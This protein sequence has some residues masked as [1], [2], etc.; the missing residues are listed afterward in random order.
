MLS[1]IYKILE[2]KSGMIFNEKE[3]LFYTDKAIYN[4]GLTCYE[5]NSVQDFSVQIKPWDNN[6]VKSYIFDAWVNSSD[7]NS[8]YKVQVKANDKNGF[9]SFS[10]NCI[11]FEQNYRRKGICKHIV[12]V[13]LKY[14]R[15]KEGHVKKE[16][17]NFQLDQ[18]ISQLKNNRQLVH[19]QEIKFF[20]KLEFHSKGNVR[21]S[22]EVKVGV[23]KLCK[24]KDIGR[25]IYAYET[26]EQ[27][28]LGKDFIYSKLKYNFSKLDT[29]FINIIREINENENLLR[30]NYVFLRDGYKLVNGNKV[31]PCDISIRRIF[32]LFKEERI[33]CVIDGKNYG[34]IPIN[35][36]LVPLDLKLLQK[37]SDYA[38]CYDGHLP[39][40]LTKKGDVMFYKGEIYL[41]NEMRFNRFKPFYEV[42][43]TG[44]N[45]IINNSKKDDLKEII[46]PEIS[47]LSGELIIDNN[48]RKQLEIDRLKA[49]FYLDKDKEEILL[50]VKFCYGN[51]SFNALT[52]IGSRDI[53]RDSYGE[54]HIIN[55]INQLGFKKGENEF[56]LNIEEDMFSF[57]QSGASLLRA[58]GEVFYSDSFKT[59]KLYNS[60][61]YR[62]QV[63]INE[64]GLLEFDFSIEG[65]DSKELWNIFKAL[66]NKKKYYKL[67]NGDFISLQ[68]KELEKVYELLEYEE[69]KF[70]R[71][72]YNNVVLPAYKSYFMKEESF[73]FVRNKECIHNDFEINSI[74]KNRYKEIPEELNGILRE[75]QKEGFR[76]FKI[77]S[78][79]G[80]GGIL[81]DEMGLGKTLQAISY[82][83]FQRQKGTSLVVAPSSLIYNW[84]SEIDKF[85]PSFKVCVIDGTKVNREALLSRYKEYQ[86][87]IT[88]Y[89]LLRRDIENYER[90]EFNCFIVDEAQY[91]KNPASMNA[92]ACKSINS[93]SKFA[94]TGTPLENNLGDIWSIFDCIMPGYLMSRRRFV[95]R[96][97]TPI[98]KESNTGALEEFNRR[99]SPFILRR[100]KNMVAKELPP[101]IEQNLLIE[102]E[103]KQK[104]VYASYAKAVRR[105]FNKLDL[106]ISTNKMKF[107]G[108]L[109]RLRQICS[110]PEVAFED[111]TG[112]N[113]KISALMDI[114]HNAKE[115]NKKI[116]VFSSFTSVLKIIEN[117]LIENTI[118]YCY[119]DGETKVRDRVPM[120]NEFN[121]GDSQVFLISLKAGGTGLNIT[122][123][124]VVV[125]Y[126]PWWNPAA[127][128]QATDRAHRIGQKNKIEVI[129]LIARG[130]IE[131]KIYELQ[132]KKRDMIQLVIGNDLVDDT[133]LDFDKIK[134]FI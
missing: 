40:P 48:L 24:I 63:R 105:D 44:K 120:V 68:E 74:K 83:Y 131:E 99:I 118:Q 119:L 125:H 72:D 33:Q 31:Y 133:R 60:S 80:F 27:I 21:T 96:Y 65:V 14:C 112:E 38:L 134:E 7:S 108:A 57:M 64:K 106:Q 115:N 94:L 95:I 34:K 9:S 128:E 35:N 127:E 13:L 126:D 42:L 30:Q 111:Y 56:F 132:N 82:I 49:E 22:L 116:I 100:E 103:E 75:Y 117:K 58:Y 61:F 17:N 67:S 107:L 78:E 59:L 84:K 53:V 18:L 113:S 91:I 62:G 26:G 54:R 28:V 39:L 4:R 55:L 92:K 123:A 51:R 114:I 130:T 109:T 29:E 88:S 97:E 69:F 2:E 50:N 5:S 8:K 129:R 3:L 37:D 122:S 11:Y 46:I 66:K 10:C 15:E 90:K 87:I 32:N 70:K 93:K 121:E 110:A 43:S 52:P 47:K 12:A 71:E 45:I 77:L 20:P 1:V 76:W 101:K 85:L 41:L 104:K 124:E 16:V 89:A 25:F 79:N 36:N 86:L 102:L 6:G 23:G 98:V 81:A 73:S 19:R